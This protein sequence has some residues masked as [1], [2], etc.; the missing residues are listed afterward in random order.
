VGLAVVTGFGLGFFIAAQVGPIWLLS[1]RTVLRGAP[2]SGLAIGAAAGL[3]DVV[4]AALGVAGAARLLEIGPT[5]TVFGILGAAVLVY[6]GSRNLVNA[7][8]IR[9]GGETDGEV[10]RPWSAFRTALVAM[11]SNPQTIAY[12]AAVFTAAS[13]SD[14]TS[15]PS[16][17]VAML[18]A[19][20]VGTFAWNAMQTGALVLIGRR[21][22]DHALRIVDGVAAVG[23]IAFGGLLGAKT[24]RER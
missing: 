17:V 14:V 11:A 6:L 18:T 2:M 19:I 5:E 20:A 4:Y 23:I 15:S 22:P 16:L 7:V 21:L 12:W 8:R 10:L 1:A 24:L 9:Q 3:V 13:T